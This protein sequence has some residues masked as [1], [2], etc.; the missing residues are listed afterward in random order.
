MDYRVSVVIPNY[1][2]MDY[3][4]PCLS[5]MRAQSRTP[6][7]IIVVDNGSL[8]GS[9]DAIGRDFPEA[10]LI[11]LAENTGFCGA[12][13]T[14]IKASWDCD[15]VILLNNDTEADTHFVEEML[16]GIAG[17]KDVFSCQAKMLKM[18]APD[19]CDDAGD[20]YCSLGWAFARGRGKPESAYAKPVSLF[21]SCAGAAIY[22]MEILRE[23]GLFDENH[24]AYLEDTDIGW[25]A[26]ICG[27]RNVFLPEARV[28]HVGS[29]STGSVYNDF[30]VRNTSRNSIYLVYKNMPTVQIILNLPLLVPGFLIKAAFFTAK[31][32]GREYIGGIR[33]GFVLCGKGKKEGKK[34]SFKK[35]NIVNYIRIQFELWANCPR[36][37]VN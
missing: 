32:F 30:K 14:G 21:S 18:D 37:L 1:N 4:K 34:V 31:G 33:K 22:N 6:D 35:K 7:R 13:N 16:R 3:Y 17:K 27:Y 15:Y 11:R 24:F 2:G 25:R 28:L 20:Y 26:R 5:S 12:V 23:I 9:A 8:D 29:A 19:L 10:D 36:R